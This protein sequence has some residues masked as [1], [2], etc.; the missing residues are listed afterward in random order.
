[1]TYRAPKVQMYWQDSN[2]KKEWNGELLSC[3]VANAQ[4]CGGGM[5]VAPQNSISDQ[6]LHL[7][8]TKIVQRHHIQSSQLCL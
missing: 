6:N 8:H 5:K 1:M 4:F 3:F 7:S 2:T